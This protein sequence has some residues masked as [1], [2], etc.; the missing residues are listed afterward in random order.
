MNLHPHGCWSDSFPLSHDRNSRVL[1]CFFVFSRI[2]ISFY[3]I[4]E[5][6]LSVL[7]VCLFVLP[8][9]LFPIKLKTLRGPPSTSKSPGYPSLQCLAQHLHTWVI[10]KHVNLGSFHLG[11]EMGSLRVQ[12]EANKWDHVGERGPWS[13]FGRALLFHVPFS[14]L[15]STSPHSQRIHCPAETHPCP[16]HPS[17][18]P[19]DTD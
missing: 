2:W 15:S 17:T 16:G 4:L 3:Q 7:F 6:F 10:S 14:T 1:G 19:W 9:A 13:W 11:S 8:K 12:G 5:D 18:I